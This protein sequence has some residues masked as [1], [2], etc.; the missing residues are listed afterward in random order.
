MKR[1]R[2]FR[3]DYDEFVST[4]KRKKLVEKKYKELCLSEIIIALMEQSAI[5]VRELAK[6]IGVSPT[7][8]QGIRS[9][10]HANITLNTLFELTSALGAKVQL[11][12]GDKIITLRDKN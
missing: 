4:P 8:I 5:S 10:K 1:L 7:V 6:E 12:I 3:S 9:G 2:K 11:E